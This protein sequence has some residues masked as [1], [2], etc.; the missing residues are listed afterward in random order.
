MYVPDVV[1][2]VVFVESAIVG[3]EVVDHTRPLV[4]TVAPPLSVI[5]PPLIAVVVVMDVTVA[6]AESVGTTAKVVKLVSVP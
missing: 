4:F 2:S 3:L 6:V 5:F 1:P